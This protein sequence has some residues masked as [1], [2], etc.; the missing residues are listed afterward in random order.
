MNREDY[1]DSMDAHYDKLNEISHKEYGKEYSDLPVN[2]QKIV[3][4]ILSDRKGSST[5]YQLDDGRVVGE[6]EAKEYRDNYG[7]MM[8]DAWEDYKSRQGSRKHQN[9]SKLI[10]S[11]LTK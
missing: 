7:K 3:E 6:Q 1:M 2:I 4:N 11:R 8:E 10:T 9:V 5:V